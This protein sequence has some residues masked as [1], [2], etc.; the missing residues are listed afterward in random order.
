M[1]I[2]PA[3]AEQ[4]AMVESFR[5][6]LHA[7]VRPVAHAYK[8]RLIPRG[9]VLELTQAIADFGLPGGAIAEEH[10]GLG[11]PWVTQAMLYEELARTSADLALVV[12]INLLAAPALLSARPEVRDRYL[13]GLIAGKSIACFGASEPGVGS[14]VADIRTR[15]RRAG[16]HFIISGEK[17]WITNGSYSDFLICT[18]R[19]GEQ[20]L[21]HILIDREEHGYEAH[22]IDKIGF[23]SQS[24]AQIFINDA[25]VPVGNV[26]GEQGMALR[27]T[28]IMFERARAHVGLTSVAIMREALAASIEYATQREQFGKKL[29]AHQLIAAKLAEMATHVD[30]SRLLCYRAL[31]LIDAGVR[32]DVESSMAKWYATEMAVKVCRDAVQLHGGNGITRSFNLES[33]LRNAIIMPIPDGTTEIQKLIISRGLTGVGAFV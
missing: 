29:A 14:N 3:T 13:P 10:G 28:L 12:M 27:H 15:A 4:E 33:Y 20:E 18:A 16:D 9:T 11:L 17:T 7:E 2:T 26:I 1:N 21:S 6:Y 8:D 5:K 19:T 32:C 30:A 22:N 31:A 24:T 25:R 23:S